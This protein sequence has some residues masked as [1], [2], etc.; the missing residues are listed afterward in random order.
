MRIKFTF[1]SSGDTPLEHFNRWIEDFKRGFEGTRQTDA[2]TPE[3]G[4]VSAGEYPSLIRGQR[5]RGA[6]PTG[7]SRG[8]TPPTTPPHEGGVFSSANPPVPDCP[9]PN[10]RDLL[11]VRGLIKN[12]A[13][14]RSINLA[15][16]QEIKAS[17]EAR[18]KEAVLQRFVSY[19]VNVEKNLV[20]LS[21]SIVVK[22]KQYSDGWCMWA[23]PGL[24]TAVEKW[25]ANMV[26]LCE[27]K[28]GNGSEGRIAVNSAY[29]RLGTTCGK[30]K[31]GKIDAI[32]E[33]GH[34][35]GLAVDIAGSQTYTSFKLPDRTLTYEEMLDAAA[36]AGLDDPYCLKGEE[37]QEY[38]EMTD[39]EKAKKLHEPWH[40]TLK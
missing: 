10:P 38:L 31:Y 26:T 40:F 5:G 1:K 24:K 33:K 27:E 35:N 2:D 20:Q 25:H 7:P 9:F 16:L 39:E 30:D 36:D 34:W 3:L 4:G 21:T 14:K 32:I 29:R 11:E 13:D 18:Y 28:G 37:Y 22:S 12:L 19:V 8:N 17:D 15:D 23:R 6:A